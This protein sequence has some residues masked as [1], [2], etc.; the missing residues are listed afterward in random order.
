MTTIIRAA[1]ALA[2]VLAVTAP[3]AA[4][5]TA[6]S[7][8]A[9]LRGSLRS[10]TAQHGVAREQGLGFVRTPAQLQAAVDSGTLVRV[11]STADF[12]VDAQVTHD[13]A[14]PEVRLLLER[15]G[16]QYRAATGTRLVVTSLIRP[17][18]EQPSNAHRLSVHPAGMAVDLRVPANAEHRE[19][20][21]RTLLALEGAGVLD[22]TREFRPPHYHVA[23]FPAAYRAYAAERL[24]AEEAAAAAAALVATR[25]AA[26]LDSAARTV[27]PAPALRA[28]MPAPLPGRGSAAPAG[29]VLAAASIGAAL[30][31][32]SR[33]RPARG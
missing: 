16:A 22:V 3:A 13:F 1:T 11:A 14:Q 26:G 25:V 9:E 6:A 28:A 27:A 21:E 23:V 29:L 32:A 24:A 33:R 4:L 20:L 5:P 17:T 19:W 15:L 30:V 10:M 12:V 8:S 7:A 31:T 2:L 18:A